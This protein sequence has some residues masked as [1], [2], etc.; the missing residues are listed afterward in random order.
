MQSFESCRPSQPVRSH[1][2]SPRGAAIDRVTGSVV[3]DMAFSL[4]GQ[5]RAGRSITASSPLPSALLS[6][7]EANSVVNGAI[8]KAR[9]L[10]TNIS[11]AVCD[12]SGN[13]IALNRMDGAYAT[14]SRL[15]IGKA[16]VSAGTGLPSGEV[17]GVVD[18]PP[19]CH[20]CRGGRARRPYSRRPTNSASTRNRRR[21]RG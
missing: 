11:V 2:V 6:L 16:I 15:S 14:A 4:Q 18:H 3:T 5:D 12:P 19:R 8:A 10:N 9:Q 7:A 21:L 20:R 13:L 17:I 1:G